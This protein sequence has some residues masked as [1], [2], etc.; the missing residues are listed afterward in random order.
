MNVLITIGLA[1]EVPDAELPDMTRK[2]IGTR[3]EAMNSPRPRLLTFLSPIAAI[4]KSTISRHINLEELRSAEV[5]KTLTVSFTNDE[6][7]IMWITAAISA[8]ATL[9]LTGI[10]SLS[11]NAI[12]ATSVNIP[13]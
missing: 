6:L 8:E 11:A 7:Q 10:I 12:T 3:H 13:T 4:K 5:P 1:K 9:S 2:N